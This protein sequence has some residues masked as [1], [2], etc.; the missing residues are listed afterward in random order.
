MSK[1]KTVVSRVLFSLVSRPSSQE[2]DKA[3]LLCTLTDVFLLQAYAN[4]TIFFPDENRPGEMASLSCQFNQFV[5]SK[6]VHPK[7]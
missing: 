6:Y 2:R 7:Q 5:T 3:G 1:Y 4:Q